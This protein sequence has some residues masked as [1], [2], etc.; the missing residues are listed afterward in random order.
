[1]F[2]KQREKRIIEPIFRGN[3]EKQVKVGRL[4]KASHQTAEPTVMEFS[5]VSKIIFRGVYQK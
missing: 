1:M 5:K 4:P 2:A 3:Y